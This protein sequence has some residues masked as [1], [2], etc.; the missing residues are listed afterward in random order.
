MGIED[1]RTWGSKTMTENSGGCF[2][3]FVAVDVVALAISSSG[4][5]LEVTV[6]TTLPSR[7]R[8]NETPSHPLRRVTGLT[9]KSRLAKIAQS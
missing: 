5:W 9:T 6:T 8:D 4:Y 2:C 3:Q 7:R 1:V